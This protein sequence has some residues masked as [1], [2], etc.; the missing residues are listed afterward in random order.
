MI[1]SLPV[2]RYLTATTRFHDLAHAAEW[3]APDIDAA[4]DGVWS[5]LLVGLR[6]R[7]IPQS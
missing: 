7:N 5:L 6:P 1:P 3:S 2:R 4:F